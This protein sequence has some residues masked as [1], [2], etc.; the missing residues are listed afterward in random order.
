MFVLIAIIAVLCSVLYL[1]HRWKYA[2]ADGLPGLK[3]VYPLLGNGDIM[4]GKSDVQRFDTMVKICSENDRLVKVWAGPKLLLF[5]CH[6]DLI[7][8]ILSSPDCLEKPFLYRFAGFEHGLFTSKYKL[9]RGTRKRLNPCFNQRILHGFFPMFEKCA[10][11][12]ID[13]LNNCL[14]GTT[15]NMHMYTT[16]CTLE[17]ACGTT[18]GSDILQCNGK[19][20]FVRSLDVAF[21]E[22]AR[23]MVSVHLYL[24]VVYRHTRYY[25]EM[26]QARELVCDFFKR[27][28]SERRKQMCGDNNNNEDDDIHKP[29]ILIDQL[30]SVSQ[31]GKTF[32]ET[33]IIDNIYAVV[34]GANDTSGL[35]IAHACLF[36]CFHQ[37][38]QEKLYA[39]IMEFIP[40]EEVEIN[41]DIL[42]QL[43]YLDMFLK[44]C[45]RHCPVAP[46]VSRENMAEMEIDGVKVPPGN[47]FV[48]NFYALHRRKDVWGPDAE[49][50]EPERFSAQRA[51]DRHPFAFLPFSGGN[52]ICIGWRYA[53]FSMKVMLTYLVRNFH[54]E[55]KI[56]QED[57]RY[58]HDL[59]MKLPFDHMI[60][61]NKRLF[62]KDTVRVSSLIHCEDGR[63]KSAGIN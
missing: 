35:L 34:T 39:E 25:N 41:P 11:K 8:Q 1:S 16:L 54:F 62:A 55:T 6:P 33:E 37:D 49:K 46:N 2:F 10:R 43:V 48:M 5:T 14:D 21:N 13:R 7:Q 36:L 50:F 28:V 24:D 56:R 3:P 22:A 30:L 32:S 63:L 40:N 27:I 12:M 20:E 4:L 9:W 26:M 52:R 38:V 47:I 42:K 51:K 31:D 15:V 23:R 57:V 45:L 44:E 58:R 17:M 61:V 60:Q 59:T 53:M 29:R 18:L 19:K